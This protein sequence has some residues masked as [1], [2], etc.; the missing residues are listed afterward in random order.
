MTET[1]IFLLENLFTLNEIFEKC[2]QNKI[3]TLLMI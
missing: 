3:Q 1:L 2:V